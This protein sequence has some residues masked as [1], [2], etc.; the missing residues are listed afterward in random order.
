VQLARKVL[1]VLLRSKEEQVQLVRKEKL[2]T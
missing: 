1:Q 2:V